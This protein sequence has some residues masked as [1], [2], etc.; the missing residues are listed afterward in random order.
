[1]RFRAVLAATGRLKQG[2]DFLTAHVP[3]LEA[4]LAVRTV[5]GKPLAY[6]EVDASGK[7]KLF[8]GRG[9]TAD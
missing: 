1:M 2:D 9:C 8:V 5:T 6:A 4:K 7:A 3:V